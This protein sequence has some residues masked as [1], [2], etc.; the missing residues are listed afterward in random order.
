MRAPMVLDINTPPLVADQQV[1]VGRERLYAFGEALHKVFGFTS[2]GLPGDRLH[3]T[4][5]ILRAMID[6]THEELNLLLVSFPF[7]HVL[8]HTN[9]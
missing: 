3:D 8:G 1:L 9:K 4:E 6:L 2:R 7:G 5:H